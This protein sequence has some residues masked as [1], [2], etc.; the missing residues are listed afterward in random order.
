MS[1]KALVIVKDG[2]IVVRSSPGVETALIVEG[3]DIDLPDDWVDLPHRVVHSLEIT[4]NRAN[5][6][7]NRPPGCPETQP[8]SPG[9][10]EHHQNSRSNLMK[11]PYCYDCNGNHPEGQCPGDGDVFARE[12]RS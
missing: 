3:E 11:A 2:T 12:G 9:S 1:G 7:Q 5:H 8:G 6:V 4:L 10:L